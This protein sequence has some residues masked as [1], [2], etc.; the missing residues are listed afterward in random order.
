MVYKLE[1]IEK[2]ID[3]IPFPSKSLTKISLQQYFKKADE[4]MDAFWAEMESDRSISVT[5]TVLGRFGLERVYE[6]EENTT[7]K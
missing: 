6:W 5:K 7:E 2:L 4:A 1:K 3:D